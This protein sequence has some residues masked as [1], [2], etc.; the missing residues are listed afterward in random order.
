MDRDTFIA[1]LTPL[2]LAMRVDFDLATWAAYYRVLSD[3][4]VPVLEAAVD[5]IS[6]EPREWFPKAGELRG[7]CEQQRRQLV[8]AHP[9]TA[10]C[11]CEDSPKWRAV[12]VE[13]VTRVEKCPC[14][15]QHRM[16]LKDQGILDP[17][18]PMAGELTGDSEQVFPTMAQLP[19]GVRERL[20]GIAG[21]KALR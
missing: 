16:S 2:L 4:S 18:A 9:W 10:C 11:L 6:R 12:L 17:I 15:E 20:T 1:I 5:A 14:V 21:Q 3:V 19:A 8:A 7:V 13:G